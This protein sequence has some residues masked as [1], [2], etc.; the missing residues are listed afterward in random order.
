MNNIALGPTALTNVVNDLDISTISYAGCM[1][2]LIIV[3]QMICES[4]RFTPISGLL[5]ATFSSN[6]SSPPLDW[7]LVLVHGWGDLFAA[8]LRAGADPNNFF[9]VPQPNDMNIVFALDAIII[10]GILFRSVRTSSSSSNPK[11]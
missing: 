9:L 10:L 1:R 5:D 8:L 4:I 2:S 11:P 7:I 6:S 3:I